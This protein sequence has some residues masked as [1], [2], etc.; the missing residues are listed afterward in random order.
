MKQVIL[1]ILAL[2]MVLGIATQADAAAGYRSGVVI[3]PQAGFAA[4]DS[5]WA[6]TVGDATN[7]F[8]W[9]RFAL[10]NNVNG[11]GISVTVKNEDADVDSIAVV[12][13]ASPNATSSSFAV[14]DSS[15]ITGS[16]ANSTMVK[17]YTTSDTYGYYPYLMTYARVFGDAAGTATQTITLRVRVWYWNTLLAKFVTWREYDL[18]VPFVE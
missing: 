14:V 2:V 1:V 3:F 13:I 16:T 8:D 4:A 18:N 7:W 9:R 15:E 10:D 6:T 12:T 17:T 5:T 11:W